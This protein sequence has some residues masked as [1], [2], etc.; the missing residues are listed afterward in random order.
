MEAIEDIILN[1]A[2]LG[3]LLVAEEQES[4]IP[5]IAL[6]EDA[7]RAQDIRK[8]TTVLQNINIFEKN[9]NLEEFK[10]LKR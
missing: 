2:E 7:I 5:T 10:R 6:A 3:I 9:I 4:I 1:I 8:F